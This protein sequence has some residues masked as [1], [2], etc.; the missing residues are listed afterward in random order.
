VVE[1]ITDPQERKKH[2]RMI[3]IWERDEKLAQEARERLGALQQ[4]EIEQSQPIRR[5]RSVTALEC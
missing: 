4:A 3:E 1:I 5:F 2:E